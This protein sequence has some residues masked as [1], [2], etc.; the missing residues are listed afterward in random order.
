L[1]ILH[2]NFLAEQ[3]ADPASRPTGPAETS[4]P[5]KNL[6]WAALLHANDRLDTL[7]PTVHVLT[8]AYHHPAR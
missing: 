3:S 8:H 4:S 1:Y 7:M 2:G 6:H 5:D